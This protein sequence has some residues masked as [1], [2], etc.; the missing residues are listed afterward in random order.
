MHKP[1]RL[2]LLSCL[3]DKAVAEIYMHSSSSSGDT[4]A[5]YRRSRR[6]PAITVDHRARMAACRVV[7]VETGGSSGPMK[8]Q[9]ASF[10]GLSLPVALC[11]VV[12]SVCQSVVGLRFLKGGAEKAGVEYSGGE[13]TDY[14]TP[15]NAVS[16]LTRNVLLKCQTEKS[17]NDQIPRRSIE[18]GRSVFVSPS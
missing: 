10:R 17:D 1:S 13:I 12:L 9:V 14:G 7:V 15:K 16:V 2:E 3:Y 6:Y 11:S 18:V 8:R 4:K 5:C